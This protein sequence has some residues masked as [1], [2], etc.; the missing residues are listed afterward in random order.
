VYP[1]PIGAVLTPQLRGTAS[2]IDKSL[3]YASTLCGACFDVCPVRIDIPSLLV[4]LRI[5]VV[6]EHRGGLPSAEELGMK[7]ASWMFGD[8]RRFEAAESAAA[9]GGKALRSKVFGGRQVLRSLPWPASVLSGARDVPVPPPSLPMLRC[10]TAG[11]AASR[12][13]GSPTVPL[14]ARARPV[15]SNSTGSRVCTGRAPCT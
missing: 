14:A 13:P 2:D 3:L 6:D 9:A 12:S 4:H 11:A 10:A 15:T 7:A 8:H 1:G 5:R